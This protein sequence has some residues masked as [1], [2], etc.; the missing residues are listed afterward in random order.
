[1]EP[2]LKKIPLMYHMLVIKNVSKYYI[3]KNNIIYNFLKLKTSSYSNAC[4]ITEETCILCL[5]NI[6][7]YYF[8]KYLTVMGF[9]VD[10]F[11]VL[12]QIWNIFFVLGVS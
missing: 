11:F 8:I 4:Y 10:I 5:Y 12:F 6:N 2:Y 9:L 1:M 3:K 7:L